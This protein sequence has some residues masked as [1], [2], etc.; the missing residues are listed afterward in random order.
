MFNF[1]QGIPQNPQQPLFGAPVNKN[2]N[3]ERKNN[4]RT[5][6]FNNL[7]IQYILLYHI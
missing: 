1:T 5:S 4:I 2:K 6:L 3:E 7:L